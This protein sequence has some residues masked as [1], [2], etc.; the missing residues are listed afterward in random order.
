M[1]TKLVRWVLTAALIYMA[2][3]ETGPWTAA[4]LFLSAV[5]T[6]IMVGVMKNNIYITNIAVRT[7]LK[8]AGKDVIGCG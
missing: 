2:Y 4:A 1:K 5:S 7:A 6:E 3:T 8:R